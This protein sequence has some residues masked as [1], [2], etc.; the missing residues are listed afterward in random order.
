MAWNASAF[1]SVA[2]DPPTVG[3]LNCFYIC[4]SDLLNYCHSWSHVD[5]KGG[6][7]GY[8]NCVRQ[9][10]REFIV[11]MVC[12]FL[13]V[14]VS[15]FC[16]FHARRIRAKKSE[17]HNGNRSTN[18]HKPTIYEQAIPLSLAPFGILVASL[19]WTRMQDVKHAPEWPKVRATI[20][21]SDLGQ[22]KYAYTPNV[23]FSYETQGIQRKGGSVFL[24]RPPMP[25]TQAMAYVEK[26]S[27]GSG[28]LVHV[29]PTD[30]D[31]AVIIPKSDESG[32]PLFFMGS[33]LALFGIG[34][35]CFMRCTR[36]RAEADD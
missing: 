26:L 31:R 3:T 2:A 27:P 12:S 4:I 23:K 17:P 35:A 9:N 13:P 18:G 34:G 5:T 29:K 19:G 8:L 24:D 33:L 6:V 10:M 22:T 32:T 7:P 20:I 16:L 30:Q 21:T 14:C 15:L 28:V 11:F 25:R 1:G 36:L